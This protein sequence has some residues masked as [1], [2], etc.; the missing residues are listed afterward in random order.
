VE[1]A[2]FYVVAEALANV[3]K[4][5][6]ASRVL[7]SAVIRD[8]QLDVSITD[9]GI[10]GADPQGHGL[11]GLADRVEALGG[12]F[13]VESQSGDGTRLRASIPHVVGS[14]G[15]VEVRPAAG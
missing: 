9:D 5:A 14:A 3:H 2:A 8:G 15:S 4:H 12:T 11:R 10:G 7:V 6:Q 13:T 1:A